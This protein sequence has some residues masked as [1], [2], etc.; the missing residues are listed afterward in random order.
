MLK[1]WIITIKALRWHLHFGWNLKVSKMYLGGIKSNSSAGE[2]LSFSVGVFPRAE[3]RKETRKRGRNPDDEWRTNERKDGNN[4]KTRKMI[5]G[6]KSEWT[7]QPSDQCGGIEIWHVRAH[8]VHVH[9]LHLNLSSHIVRKQRFLSVS[10]AQ[11]GPHCHSKYV[12]IIWH[13][14]TV[15]G[16]SVVLIMKHSNGFNSISEEKL[17]VWF[18][19]IL[20][21]VLVSVSPS[22]FIAGFC[23]PAASDG[24]IRRSPSMESACRSRRCYCWIVS[25]APG[26]FVDWVSVVML[27]TCLE[28]WKLLPLP[29][30]VNPCY[31]GI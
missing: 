10:V 25:L 9:T 27:D 19:Q 30:V 29:D 21:R 24:F 16:I 17:S 20:I 31:S 5:F 1:Y 22:Q 26:D 7:V 2:E 14:R 28:K 8:T 23:D 4:V 3:G 6:R 18:S 12:I 11:A 13:I 15:R